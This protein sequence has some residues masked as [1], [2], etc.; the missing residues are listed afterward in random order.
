LK[1]LVW[2]VLWV[3][4]T[5]RNQPVPKVIPETAKPRVNIALCTH[6]GARHLDAQLASYDTQTHTAWDLWVSDDGSQDQTREILRGWRARWAGHH[7][8][9][10]LCGPGKGVAANYMTLL[11]QADFDNGA[12]VALSDQDDVWHADKL[13]RGLERMA[14]C[15][16]GQAVL[17][18]AQSQYVDENLRPIGRSH[19]ATQE[20]SF[21]NALVQNLVSGH[22]AVLNPSALALVRHVGVPTGIPYHDWWLYQLISAAG[23][24]VLVDDMEMLLY[25]QHGANAMGAHQGLAA[26]IVRLRQVFD[27]T[28]GAWLRANFAALLQAGDSLNDE[29]RGTLETLASAP[30]RAGLARVRAFRRAGL[31]RRGKVEQM[32]FDLGAWLGKI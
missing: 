10:I 4:E 26:R 24:K 22:S 5:K 7:D 19:R 21:G 6:N 29:N 18:G 20:P 8:V 27:G 31:H 16:A 14:P 3:V 1:S 9:H 25:R 15:P 17:Y 12:Y 32:V 2:D 13:A 28:Y 23:G 11:C 30:Q